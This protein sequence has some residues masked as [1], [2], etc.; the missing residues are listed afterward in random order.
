MSKSAEARSV[1]SRSRSLW[2]HPD[3]M[4]LW[5]GETISQLGTQ[6]T[7]L[8]L[9]LTAVVI[10]KANAFQVGLLSTL[11]FLPFILVGLPAGV[12]V[13]RLRRR[14]I[15]IAG[16]LLRALTLGSIPL[17]YEL[18][19][20]HMDQLY[21]VAF[22]TGIGTVFFDV[23]YQAYLPSLVE[24]DQIVDGNSKLEISRSGAQLAGP[25]IA[26]ILIQAIKA[27]VAIL[28]DAVSYL[29]SAIFVGLIRRP[30]A[31]VDTAA[32][33]TRPK[34]RHEIREGLRYVWRHELLRPIALCTATG[35]LFGS[36]AF[37]ILILFAVRTLHL[38]AGEIG[39][40]FALGNVGFLFGAFS[41]RRIADRIG[42]GPAIIWSIGLTSPFYF[43][44]PLATPSTAFAFLVVEGFA[45]GWG[46][47]AVYNINQV[48]LRQ[49]ITPDRMQGKMNATMRFMV[50]GTI[51]IGSFL[52]GV[53]GRSIGLRPTLWIG[54][55]GGVLAFLWPLLSPV[56]RLRVIPG[57]PA[58]QIPETFEAALVASEEGLPEPGSAARP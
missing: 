13:D 57:A 30:E 6:V 58:E 12:W 41:A 39:V 35:N 25:G 45:V 55:A 51:P 26:G 42:V 17:A 2:R 31:P 19:A 7:L 34:M 47:M 14:P 32:T 18:H 40:I 48:S 56:R 36:I 3:F 4:K 16:D 15:L 37:A 8:A 27:P 20:L 9:P 22:L 28:V 10:L 24:R 53:L 11:E 54:A 5:T 46:A 44:V 38:K 43:L 1:A 29:W 49:A 33:G 21:L 52:G 23:A 50:W